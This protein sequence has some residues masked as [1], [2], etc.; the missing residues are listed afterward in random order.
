MIIHITIYHYISLYQLHR[1]SDGF[2]LLAKAFQAFL[3][4]LLG[5]GLRILVVTPSCRREMRRSEE[6]H[7]AWRTSATPKNAATAA[8]KVVNCNGLM[9]FSLFQMIQMQRI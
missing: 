7:V 2:S 6:P 1:S 3:S 8:T 4:Q 9:V 5:R